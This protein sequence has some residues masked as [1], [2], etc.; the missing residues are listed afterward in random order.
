MNEKTSFAIVTGQVVSKV[1]NYPDGTAG[2]TLRNVDGVIY[3]KTR[4]HLLPHLKKND[5]VSVVGHLASNQTGCGARMF[6]H[7]A[8]ILT[9]PYP[10]LWDDIGIPA[11]LRT[12]YGLEQA[13]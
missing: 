10:R 12:I 8:A 13:Q 1:K 4:R 2:F 6:V 5:R 3:I 9:A 7:A 11:L